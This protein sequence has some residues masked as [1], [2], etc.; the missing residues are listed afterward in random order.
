MKT[1]RYGAGM[2]WIKGLLRHLRAGSRARSAAWLR[3]DTLG[4]ESGLRGCT[5]GDKPQ[6]ETG[7]R[8]G[9]ANPV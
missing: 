3:N 1:F 8:V 2:R 7:L 5:V 6:V 9:E 4:K